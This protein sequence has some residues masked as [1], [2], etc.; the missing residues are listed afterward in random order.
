MPVDEAADAVEVTLTFPVFNEKEALRPSVL[1]AQAAMDKLPYAYEILLVDDGST[2]GCMDTVRDLDVRIIRHLHNMDGAMARMTGIRYAKGDIIVQS[3]ADG[4]YPADAIGPMLEKLAD[5]DMVIGARKRESA[6]D[7][8]FARVAMKWFMRK[9]A[10]VLSG[11]EIPDLNSGL[12]AYR[13]E[14]ALRY[15]H[16]YPKG[17]SMMSTLT[18]S[19]I[20]NGLRVYFYPID[21]RQRVGSSTFRPIRDT[22]NYL[23]ITVRTVAF[24]NPLRVLLPM[25]LFLLGAGL[26]VG[27]VNLIQTGIL[28]RLPA[29]LGIGALVVLSMGVLSDQFAKLSKQLSYLKGDHWPDRYI[30]EERPDT[31]APAEVS[32]KAD[33]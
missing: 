6:Q 32:R 9:L 18:L 4:T 14:T 2:D 1:E 17:H 33:G 31:P 19:F 23:L 8:H 7:W 16:L 15:A 26:A 27:V 25:A 30:R 13:K 28:G 24:F 5:C 20:T 12:R 29:F 22:Y 21:Y 3:D 11:A 10:E